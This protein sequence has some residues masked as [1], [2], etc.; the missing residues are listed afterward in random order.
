MNFEKTKSTYGNMLAGTINLCF[1]FFKLCKEEHTVLWDLNC[2]K[3]M[4]YSQYHGILGKMV[5]EKKIYIYI[6]QSLGGIKP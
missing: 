5:K 6:D 4:I 1:I 3:P 2:G